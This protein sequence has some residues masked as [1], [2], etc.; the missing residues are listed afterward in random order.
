MKNYFEA[1]F[2]YYKFIVKRFPSKFLEV[3]STLTAEIKK[4][5][6]LRKVVT[7]NTLTHLL[8]QYVLQYSVFIRL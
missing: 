8:P 3:R 7:T 2:F 5:R 4:N 1:F 6:R